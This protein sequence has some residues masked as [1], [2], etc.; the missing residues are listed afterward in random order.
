MGCG[1]GN[2]ANAKTIKKQKNNNIVTLNILLFV[3]GAVL[4]KGTVLYYI[5]IQLSNTEP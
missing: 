3:F 5:K 2:P 1:V 4:F